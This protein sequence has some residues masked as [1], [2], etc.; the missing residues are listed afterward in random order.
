MLAMDVVWRT[1]FIYKMLRGE[2]STITSTGTLLSSS[3]LPFKHVE[4]PIVLYVVI[5]RHTSVWHSIV[6][7]LFHDGPKLEQ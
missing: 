1:V 3:P 4:L 6:H 5:Y 2:E 7:I